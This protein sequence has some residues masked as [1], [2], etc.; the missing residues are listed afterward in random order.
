MSAN[1]NPCAEIA[2]LYEDMDW[3]RP[4]PPTYI[5]NLVNLANAVNKPKSTLIVIHGDMAGDQITAVKVALDLIKRGPRFVFRAL[6][7]DWD[8]FYLNQQLY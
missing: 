4:R 5:E 1:D 6:V 8:P 7:E 2:K 3:L